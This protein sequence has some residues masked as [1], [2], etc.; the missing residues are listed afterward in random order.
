MDAHGRSARR[1]VP[2]RPRRV[3]QTVSTLAD[4]RT[5]VMSVHGTTRATTD[6]SITTNGAA[7][8]AVHRRVGASTVS[9]HAAARRHPRA[10]AYVHGDDAVTYGELFA[11][12]RRRADEVRRRHRSSPPVALALTAEPSVDALADLLAVL[13]AGH[14][15]VILDP[16]WPAAGRAAVTASHGA[17][18]LAVAAAGEDLGVDPDA[19]WWDDPHWETDEQGGGA[20]TPLDWWRAAVVVGATG[21]VGARTH[22]ELHLAAVDLARRAG[23]QPG[24]VFDLPASA[25]TLTGLVS[26]FAG[27]TAGATV[28]GWREPR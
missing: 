18:P 21:V 16:S 13:S 20:P 6:M 3:K 1:V 14:V 11:L 2:Q 9:L 8:A 25:A 24:T 17:V 4:H 27:L 28:N 15:A 7:R 22:E 5:V 12:V 26:L 10:T 23:L 19:L